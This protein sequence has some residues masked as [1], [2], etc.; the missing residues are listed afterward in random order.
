MID[1]VERLHE[2]L[3]KIEEVVNR[4]RDLSFFS[5]EKRDAI[6]GDIAG[7]RN[8]TD[9]FEEQT[10]TVGILGGTGVGKSSLMNALA[11][12]VI[13]ST[14]HRRPHTDAILLYRH[15]ETALPRKLIH[16]DLQW[17]E[18]THEAEEIGRILLCDLP[19]FDSIMERHR[20]GVIGF[21]EHLD[22]LVW[23]VSP[24]KYGDAGFY[25]FLHSVPKAKDNFFF[26]LNKTDIFFD[27]D[28][29]GKGREELRTVVERLQGYLNQSGID[30]PRLYAVSTREA[31]LTPEMSFWNQFNALRREIFRQ[32]NVKEVGNIKASNIDADI[33]R[34]LRM[35]K[36]DTDGFDSLRRSLSALIDAFRT[37]MPE[38]THNAE[39]FTK[40][41]INR[42][43]RDVLLR[44]IADTSLLVGPTAGVYHLAV[45][46]L[47]RPS[48]PEKRDVSGVVET[49]AAGVQ[50]FFE[51]QFKSLHDRILVNLLQNGISPPPA[52]RVSDILLLSDRDRETG[53][54][55]RE[56]FQAGAT[57]ERT[58]PERFFMILQYA[59]YLAVTILFVFA[60]GG[61][62]STRNI[63]E[64]PGWGSLL[65]F[66]ASSAFAL[67][68][69]RGLV[70]LA[71]FLLINGILGYRFYLR[72]KRITENK[73]DRI[74]GRFSKK[75]AF[76]WKALSDKRLEE[77]RGVCSETG[78]IRSFLD[79]LAES[80]FPS[81][82]QS[83]P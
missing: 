14:D 16:A 4:C 28:D 67:F 81:D 77:L 36:V 30:T 3:R 17:K 45:H 15:R 2:T 26:I 55:L 64:D 82:A 74:I 68:S 27:G 34:L 53:E 61:E 20:E 31:L 39:H 5:A 56:I 75:A 38:M 59:A 9:A 63:L 66:F 72:H 51:R 18:I 50:D 43:Y 52:R 78:M 1:T 47:E 57:A 48:E 8:R 6:L 24:E 69:L 60:L 65:S 19:D 73:T 83:D 29:D 58:V 25:D 23:M 46:R 54:R 40:Q 80:R 62:E 10:L 32:R 13:S 22:L 7:I 33:Q 79:E 44:E 71:G 35:L 12:S 37:E 70:A 42:E 21:L 41:A 11:G 49:V 76:L